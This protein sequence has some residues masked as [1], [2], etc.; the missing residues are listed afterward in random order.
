MTDPHVTPPV[1]IDLLLDDPAGVDDD[2]SVVL[3]LDDVPDPEDDDTVLAEPLL[4]D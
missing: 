1:E 2:A 4:L 3:L